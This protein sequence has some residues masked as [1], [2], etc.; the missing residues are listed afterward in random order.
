MSIEVKVTKLQK[1]N[2]EQTY[3]KLVSEFIHK[4]YSPDDETALINNYLENPSEYGEEYAE[5]QAYRAE[6][7]QAV[8]DAFEKSGLGH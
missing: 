5:Y 4:R 2:R 6:V 1:K 8:K 3:P 7:K